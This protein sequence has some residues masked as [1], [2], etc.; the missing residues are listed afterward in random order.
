MSKLTCVE[1]FVSTLS[2]SAD[3]VARTAAAGMMALVC[4]NVLLRLFGWPILGTYEVVSFL[5]AITVAFALPYCSLQKGHI[6]VELIVSRLPL[7]IQAVIDLIVGVLSLGLFALF[8]WQ[9]GAF[10]AK[11]HQ[12]GEIT[13]TL[14]LPFFPFIF[15]VAFGCLLVCPVL[16]IDIIKSVKRLKQK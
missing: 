9:V 16:I 8:S 2:R 7:R 11:I 15:G 5:V 1:R 14:K 13:D 10:A 3:W 6:A 4:V 12:T